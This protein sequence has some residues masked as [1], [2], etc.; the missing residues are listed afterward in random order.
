MQKQ[1]DHLLQGRPKSIGD[2]TVLQP[3]PHKDFRFANP[4]IVLHHLKPETIPA[5]SPPIR[6]HPHPHR[7]FAP[8]TFVFQGEGFHKDSEGNNGIVKEGGVQFMF[9]G[10]GLLHSE[11]PTPQLLKKGGVY[12]F[13]QLWV[14]VPANNKWDKPFY[15]QA[16]KEQLPAVSLED[17]ID[18]RLA[19]GTYNGLKA[20]IESITPVTAI[21]GS[22]SSSKTFP[23]T[24]P[25]NYWTLLYI[26]DGSVIINE[27]VIAAQY[28]V[29]F[30]KEGENILV[31]AKENTK[32][33]Y[34]YAEPINEPV[35]AKG[36]IV[37]NTQEEV[38]QAEKDYAEGKFGLLN[39]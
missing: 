14:N 12:E 38:A 23:L 18:L 22:V 9:A 7:G 39:F 34:L 27:K 24:A 15:K 2:E 25:Q 21:F 6:V 32:L 4:F 8:V 35:A 1:I 3:L 17:G 11:G 19:L 36:N 37:M 10:S 28:L 33:L 30:S 5:N 16:A 31:T 20:P 29:V 26:L 13:V